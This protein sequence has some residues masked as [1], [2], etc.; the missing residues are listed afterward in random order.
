[1]LTSWFW[2]IRT[3]LHLWRKRGSA[4]V[5]AP[6]PWAHS[7]SPGSY[8]PS[9]SSPQSLSGSPHEAPGVLALWFGESGVCSAAQFPPEPPCSQPEGYRKING[10]GLSRTVVGS[11]VDIYFTFR[12]RCQ[13]Q[14][15][16][17]PRWVTTPGFRVLTGGW[18][19]TGFQLLFKKNSVLFFQD[20]TKNAIEYEISSPEVCYCTVC[21][22]YVAMMWRF[23]YLS[24][25]CLY[26]PVAA[27]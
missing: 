6:A 16:W 4:E 12:K 26:K 15:P 1:M 7:S 23:W 5:D 18:W 25:R 27:S 3:Y 24:C 9:G 21:P 19:V 11:F 13:D 10:K 20:W 22:R 17:W 8:F 2:L 14:A